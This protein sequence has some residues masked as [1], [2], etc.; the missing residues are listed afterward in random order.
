MNRIQLAVTLQCFFD[1]VFYFG[2]AAHV[3]DDA[4]MIRAQFSG[5][6]FDAILVNRGDNNFRAF[7]GIR[8]RT[9]ISNTT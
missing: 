7:G 8:F 3:A 9:I 2:V 6:S 5:N 4:Q 1:R